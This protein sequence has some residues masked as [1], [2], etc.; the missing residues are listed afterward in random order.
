[1]KAVF[2]ATIA[3]AAL[4]SASTAQQTSLDFSSTELSAPLDTTG[5]TVGADADAGAE[6]GAEAT[7]VLT[8]RNSFTNSLVRQQVLFAVNDRRKAAGL[9][10]LCLN[11]KLMKAAQLQAN[12]LAKTNSITVTGENSTSPSDRGRAA[13]FNSTGLAEL[14]GAGYTKPADMITAWFG[15]ADSKNILLGNYTHIGP[16]YTVD[17]KQQYVYYWAVDFSSSAG[18]EC[19]GLA[20]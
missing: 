8:A 20:A 14:V 6:V 16:G 11:Y 17:A 13:G 3:L 18:E 7:V 12:Y 9:P 4:F 5:E 19:S 15:S 1:M 10:N 2:A